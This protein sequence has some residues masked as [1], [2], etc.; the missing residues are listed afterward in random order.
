MP[1]LARNAFANDPDTMRSLSGECAP[2]MQTIAAVSRSESVTSRLDDL[3]ISCGSH[4]SSLDQDALRTWERFLCPLRGEAFDLLQIGVGAGASLRT[5][6]VWFPAARLIALD[7]RRNALTPPIANCTIVHGSQ[8]DPTVLRHLLRDHRFR[9]I[10]DDGSP[11]PDHKRQTF[12]TLFPW[13][14]SD[15]VY[16]CAG[17][18][19]PGSGINDDAG[20]AHGV[21]ICSDG[22]TLPIW[23]ANFALA[24]ANGIGWDRIPNAQ[25]PIDLVLER[26]TGVSLLRGSTVVTT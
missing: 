13:L 6:R 25:D 18:G 17:I 1:N 16:C 26:A 15:S 21:A 11:L 3:G 10:V 19:D 7:V 24:L 12:L 8:S 20:L 14:E 23:F 22:V 5:W 2:G 4:L 9:L